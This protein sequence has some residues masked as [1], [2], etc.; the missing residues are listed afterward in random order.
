MSIL[1][2]YGFTEN[3]I[4][5]GS[6][7]D[8]LALLMYE[9]R[10]CNIYETLP[11][12]PGLTVRTGDGR[13][14]VVETVN[15]GGNY[16]RADRL[17]N[18]ATGEPYIPDDYVF[19]VIDVPET[20]MGRAWLNLSVGRGVLDALGEKLSDLRERLT[21]IPD[22]PPLVMDTQFLEPQDPNKPPH[23][24]LAH[25]WISP[26]NDINF[27]YTDK[28]GISVNGNISAYA[29]AVN[30]LQVYAVSSWLLDEYLDVYYAYCVVLWWTRK[31]DSVYAEMI[32]QMQREA[33][34]PPLPPR[35]S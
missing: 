5:A 32:E 28:D 23:G 35:L 30:D 16:P 4:S 31:Y 15:A 33:N 18:L 14:Y 22:L 25:T 7:A 34:L 24:P 12:V 10:D 1:K 3:G 17:T 21:E 26:Q 9:D 29:N 11:P 19:T 13:E 6:V 20:S 27:V 8:K 2:D